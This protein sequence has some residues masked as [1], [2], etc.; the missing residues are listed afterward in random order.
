MKHVMSPADICA[1][2]GR[3]ISTF[4]LRHVETVRVIAPAFGS[5]FFHKPLTLC[6]LVSR[7]TSQ[8]LLLVAEPYG[9]AAW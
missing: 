2:S 3:D 6:A 7:A 4:R 8:L 9:A 5:N 1:Q